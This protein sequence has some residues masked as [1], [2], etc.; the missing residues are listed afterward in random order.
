MKTIVA[1]LVAVALLAVAAPA[2]ARPVDAYG[3][4][5][6]TERPAVSPS[7]GTEPWA[8]IAAAVLAFAA[9]AGAARLAPVVR[10]RVLAAGAR[11]S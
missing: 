9:G 5:P 3:P 7:S 8:V 1:V 10:P 11:R 6:S 2:G 4:I